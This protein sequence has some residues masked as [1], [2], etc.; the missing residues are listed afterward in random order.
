MNLHIIDSSALMH[1]GLTSYTKDFNVY[2][3][4]TGAVFNTLKIITKKAMD[5]ERDIF[6]FTFDRKPVRKKIS[7]DYKKGR[8]KMSKKLW[9]QAQ[10]L[11]KMVERMGFNALAVE[12]TEADDIIY[13]L[14]RKYEG[15]FDH[16]Y[17]YGTDRD[18]A[19]N[20]S[21]NCT[22]VSTNKNVVDVTMSNFSRVF[23]RDERVPYNTTL[24]Y[25]TLRQDRSDG[26]K[27]LLSY[28]KFTDLI[29][30][31]EIIGNQSGKFGLGDLRRPELAEYC[32][33]QLNG[34]PEL[35]KEIMTRWALVKPIQVDVDIKL[36][37][38]I[39]EVWVKKYC[40]AFALKQMA[41]KVG[42][43]YSPAISGKWLKS[44][45]PMINEIKMEEHLA[46]GK[47]IKDFVPEHIVTEEEI[48]D[49]F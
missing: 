39:D 10:L 26:L 47:K 3:F 15:T 22:L 45:E 2:G 29:M 14:C 37:N 23:D 5:L 9:Y 28:D 11:E 32:L 19:V 42:V 44:L 41:N 40:D 31:L 46:G 34:G 35:M 1:A 7:S 49:V 16:I 20:V 25:K 30:K 8:N 4:P 48:D 12:D 33:K 43:D 21:N 13:S 18:L 27:V 38:E 6:V 36:T 24:L 17:I